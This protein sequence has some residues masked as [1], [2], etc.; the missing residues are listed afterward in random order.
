VGEKRNEL[1]KRL[2]KKG[3]RRTR[4]GDGGGVEKNNTL[5]RRKRG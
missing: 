5:Q 1:E 2:E 4:L 3:E